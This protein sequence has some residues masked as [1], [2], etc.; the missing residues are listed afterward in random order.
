MNATQ[1]R[2]IVSQFRT[3]ETQLRRLAESRPTR[4]SGA[5]RRAMIRRTDDRDDMLCAILDSHDDGKHLVGA[6]NDERV[7]LERLAAAKRAGQV[8]PELKVRLSFIRGRI[9]AHIRNVRAL[10]GA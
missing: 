2:E 1:L 6:L 5:T 8:R 9:N 3:N 7:L 10:H 4:N